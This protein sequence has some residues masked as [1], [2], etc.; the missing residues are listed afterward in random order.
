MS[1]RERI[2]ADVKTLPA[3]S[4]AA[5]QIANVLRDPD[6][7]IKDV[8]RIVEYDPG[9]TANVL[10]LANSSYFGGS[11]NIGSIQQAIVRLGI[12]KL[13]DLVTVSATHE[14][15]DKPIAGYEL[16]PGELWRH[17][18]AV[19]ITAKNLA[20]SLGIMA[21][22]TA[23]TAGL[24]HDIGKVVIGAFVEK[25]FDKIDA[26]AKASD[27]SFETAERKI[28]GIDHAEIGYAVLDMWKFPDKITRAVRFHH[29][30]EDIQG[31]IP[32]VDAVHIA[33]ILCLMMGIGPGREGLRYRVSDDILSRYSLTP[34]ILEKIVSRSIDDMK[35]FAELFGI[36]SGG[37]NCGI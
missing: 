37:V 10:R 33:D 29:R 14:V 12:D 36:Q 28:L 24:L 31:G 6:V 23:F 32:E 9:M 27:L 19:A 18:V 11:Y 1:Y 15:I 13:F 34:P 16:P 35:R 17:S 25:D 26:I 3:I 8:I 22:D 7:D 20:N 4:T 5:L 21:E 30:P 2:L